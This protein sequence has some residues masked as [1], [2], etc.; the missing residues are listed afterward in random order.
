MEL[1]LLIGFI[2]CIFVLPGKV[3]EKKFDNY[4]PPKGYM[5]DHGKMNKD[6]TNGVS[7]SEIEK[8]A[9]AGKYNVPI[10]DSLKPY[11]KNS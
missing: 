8:N 2:Y 4:M 1:L 6:I 9:I 7:K 5:V 10:P 3:T 11:H